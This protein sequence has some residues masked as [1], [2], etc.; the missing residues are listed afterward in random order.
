M[1]ESI[2]NIA[3]EIRRSS[4]DS[5]DKS[6]EEIQTSSS[7]NGAKVPKSDKPVPMETSP[8]KEPATARRKSRDVFDFPD[9]E[10]EAAKPA[11]IVNSK[12]APAAPS[13]ENIIEEAVKA[14]ALCPGHPSRGCGDPREETLG[15]RRRSRR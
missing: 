5:E 15:S 8:A 9:D 10:E 3:A 13:V 12:V 14:P 1:D 11:S 6:Q 4:T 2:E 7:E